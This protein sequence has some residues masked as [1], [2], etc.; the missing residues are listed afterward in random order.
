M[1]QGMF[2]G[3][4][5]VL[6]GRR[7][8]F[9]SWFRVRP[10]MP[11]WV[12]DSGE[13]IGLSGQAAPDA[14]QFRPSHLPR[15]VRLAVE[16]PVR[17]P[18]PMLTPRLGERNLVVISVLRDGD[19]YLGWGKCDTTDG[20]SF[21]MFVTSADGVDWERPNLGMISH[22]GT[23]DNNYI[24]RISEMFP[25]RA[26]SG[27]SVFID[28]AAGP[29]ERF[30]AV[31]PHYFAREEVANYLATRSEEVDPKALTNIALEHLGF[32][33]DQVFGVAGLT[34][35][36]GIDWTWLPEPL[37]IMHSDSQ[38]I[39]FYDQVTRRY[40][41]MFREWVVGEH[42]E[43]T[44]RPWMG[45]ENSY[46]NA[47]FE[48]G[49]RVLARAETDD[50]T[51]WPLPQPVLSDTPNLRPTESLYTGFWSTFPGAPDTQLL[52]PTVW[53]TATDNH[54]VYICSATDAHGRSWQWLP[55]GCLLKPNTAGTWDGGTV[56]AH[57]GLIELPSGDFALPYAGFDAPH[58]YPR[59]QVKF[60]SAF[61][62]WPKG[63]VVGIRADETGEFQTVSVLAVGRRAAVNCLSSRTGYVRA[64]VRRFDGSVVPGRDLDKCAPLIGDSYG[65]ELTWNGESDLGVADG[66]PVSLRFEL[67]DASVYWVEFRD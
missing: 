31:T 61:I 63:R 4:P 2:L 66:E 12:S 28:P 53:D 44:G 52:F 5:Y 55:D 1:P 16:R 64:E 37:L 33:G 19:R 57:P 29:K 9:T 47:W 50:F 65:R 18:A 26:I 58:K 15:G 23:T 8:A 38:I 10:G 20:Q 24:P 11:R 54:A 30:K 49:Q 60:G 3:E 45:S 21:S 17:D 46:A 43:F 22:N 42:P 13:P 7:L 35:P 14:A 67:R 39:C 25:G 41:G 59:S 40:V 56:F 36:D 62:R 6:A 27:A 32:D 34:S 51:R 48:V